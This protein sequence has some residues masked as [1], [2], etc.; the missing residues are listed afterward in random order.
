MCPGAIFEP[1]L[2]ERMSVVVDVK[3]IENTI[4]KIQE[5]NAKRRGTDEILRCKIMFPVY[6]RAPIQSNFAYDCNTHYI[7][8]V[9]S[10][11]FVNEPT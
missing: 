4:T 10:V 3:E 11:P 5:V 2:P 7:F 1:N 6:Y 9:F 8:Q